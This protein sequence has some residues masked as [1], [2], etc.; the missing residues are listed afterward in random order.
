MFLGSNNMHQIWKKTNKIYPWILSNAS[1][2][3]DSSIK[4]SNDFNLLSL[5]YIALA[6]WIKNIPTWIKSE[7]Y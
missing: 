6:V 2:K 5:L 7:T 1:W 4:H 3:Y